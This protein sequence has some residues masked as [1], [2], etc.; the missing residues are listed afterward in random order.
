VCVLFV[1]SHVCV[2]LRVYLCVSVRVY[3]R[4]CVWACV[5]VHV[6]V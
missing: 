1:C 2:K 5:C 4:M 3:E 6:E